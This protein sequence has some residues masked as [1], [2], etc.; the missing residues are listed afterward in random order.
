MPV[1]MEIKKNLQE[2]YEN[3]VNSFSKAQDIKT[4]NDAR[5][6]FLGR[7]SELQNFLKS[8]GKM[9]AEERPQAGKLINE[10]RN[11]IEALSSETESKI[12][13]SQWDSLKTNDSLD[14]TE[15]AIA[16]SAGASHI[17]MQILEEVEDIFVSMGFDVFDGPEIESEA[18]NFEGLNIPAEHPARDMQDTFWMNNGLL[19]RTHTS[20][21]QVRSLRNKKLPLRGIAPGRVFRYEELDRSHSHTFHQVECIL[22]DKDVSVASLIGVIRSFL[23]QLFKKEVKVRIR[24]GYF[25][26]VEPGFEVDF[27]CLLCKGK[28]CGT[29]KQTGW[30]EFMGAGLVHPQVFKEAGHDADEWQGF[31][32]GFGLERLAMMRYGITDIRHFFGGD[33]RF[34]GQFS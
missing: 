6:Q 3:A 27:A 21:I 29:C 20:P 19:M 1:Y 16:P 34:L 18:F 30:L 23:T 7:K 22:V 2:L 32:F 17:L 12:Q 8:L 33:L 31:A 15:P 24:P 9:S 4:W 28:G 26:F 13:N 25:P 11:K 10:I 14:I 5:V